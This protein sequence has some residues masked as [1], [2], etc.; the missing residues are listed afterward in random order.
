MPRI[1]YDP[2]PTL[3]K[4]CLGGEVGILPCDNWLAFIT[5]INVTFFTQKLFDKYKARF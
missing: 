4:M 2:T 5:R 3:D 1:Y